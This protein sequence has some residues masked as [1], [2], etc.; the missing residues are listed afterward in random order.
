VYRRGVVNWV[1][2]LLLAASV[3]FSTSQPAA[4]APTLTP[5]YSALFKRMYADPTNI[6]V[7]F[8]FA[9]LATQLGDYEAAIGAL[10]RILLFNPNLPRVRLQLGQLYFKLGGYRMARGLFEQAQSAPGAPPELRTQAAEFIAEIDRRLSPHKFGFFGH[11]GFRHQSNANAGPNSPL[12]R[13]L[14]QDVAINTQFAKQPDW[15][16]F[17]MFGANYSY[18]PQLASGMTLEAGLVGYYAKQFKLHQFDLGLIEFQ[19]GPR[20]PVP[21]LPGVSVRPYAILTAASI[22]SSLYYSGP[23]AGFSSLFNVGAARLEPYVEYRQRNYESPAA[24]PTAIQQSGAL[25]TMAVAGDGPIAGPVSWFGRAAFDMNRVGNPD[26]QFNEYH[27]WAL[28]LGFPIWFEPKLF[29][30]E[31]YVTPT[32]GFSRTRF[33]TSNPSVDPLATRLDRAWQGGALIDVQLYRNIGL[34]TQVLYTRNK[35]NLANFDNR[36]LSVIFGPTVRF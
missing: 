12:I 16:W 10:E 32:I 18:D 35:S 28:D 24:F 25:W 33:A 13:S 29:G 31:I 19:A 17:G 15:N 2:G 26:L 11:T 20:F 36:N 9:E 3:V 14:G 8:R 1:A 5:E 27:R 4:A 7:T 34:R 21:S 22:D 6:E 23:G 30:R